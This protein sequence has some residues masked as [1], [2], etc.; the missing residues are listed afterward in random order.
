[1]AA[2]AT[3]SQNVST[4]PDVSKTPRVSGDRTGRRAPQGK[5][6]GV[7]E[8]IDRTPEKR[9]EEKQKVRSQCT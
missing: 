9:K 4:A 8:A 1:M 3:P 5:K 6:G 7:E 2:L